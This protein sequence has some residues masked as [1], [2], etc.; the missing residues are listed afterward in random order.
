MV[1]TLTHK[2]HRL[3]MMKVSTVGSM[4]V[5]AGGVAFLDSRREG[6]AMS[7]AGRGAGGRMRA[8]GAAVLAV[9][10]VLKP[11]ATPGLP[12]MCLQYE[13]SCD[14]AFTVAAGTKVSPWPRGLQA[15]P[16]TCP[17]AL[18]LPPLRFRPLAAV[19]AASRPPTGPMLPSLPPFLRPCRP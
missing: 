15:H 14:A 13:L 6:T 11:C 1:V 17:P 4:K 5:S 9:L 16:R 7:C 2:T 10:A 18:P 19:A 8:A 12:A 3:Q